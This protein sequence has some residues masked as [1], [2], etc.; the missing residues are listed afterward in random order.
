[1]GPPCPISKENGR[2]LVSDGGWDCR[3][4]VLWETIE[5]GSAVRGLRKASADGGVKKAPEQESTEWGW[6]H[7]CPL[8]CEMRGHGSYDGGW[9]ALAK[10]R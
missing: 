6:A 10:Q 8:L 9:S 7:R 3:G 5:Y 2:I 1:M 4:P